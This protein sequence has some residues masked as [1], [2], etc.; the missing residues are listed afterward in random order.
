MFGIAQELLAV[1]AHHV[2]PQVKVR[3]VLGRQDA[4][5]LEHAG[6]H[7]AEQPTSDGDTLGIP[8]EEHEAGT[9]GA[10]ANGQGAD[11]QQQRIGVQ[12]ERVSNE[13]AERQVLP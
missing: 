1:L 4:G 9:G 2:A 6:G 12:V 8:P 10:A 11:R 13:P 5:R 3:A 7:D